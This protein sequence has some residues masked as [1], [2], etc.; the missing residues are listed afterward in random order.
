MPPDSGYKELLTTP[1]FNLYKST[2]YDIRYKIETVHGTSI[3]HLDCLS[4]TIFRYIRH[5]NHYLFQKNKAYEYG[6]IRFLTGR[7]YS[8]R[9]KEYV[10]ETQQQLINESLGAFEMRKLEVGIRC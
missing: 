1:L 6:D 8:T 9:N 4:E 10:E 7:I 3:V 5:Y 2:Y